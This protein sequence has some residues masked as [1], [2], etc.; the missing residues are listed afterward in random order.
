LQK[1]CQKDTDACHDNDPKEFSSWIDCEMN[2]CGNEEM[3]SFGAVVLVHSVSVHLSAVLRVAEQI[4][5]Y[6][7]LIFDESAI[8]FQRHVEIPSFYTL[9]ICNKLICQPNKK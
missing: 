9:T 1:E 5:K 3:V 6:H 2:M 7:L 8:S 4:K